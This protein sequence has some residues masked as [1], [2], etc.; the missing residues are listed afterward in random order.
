MP[1][2]LRQS[3]GMPVKMATLQT[4]VLPPQPT[5]I[6]YN[7]NSRVLQLL[8]GETLAAGRSGNSS[9]WSILGRFFCGRFMEWG[10]W[11]RS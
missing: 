1:K 7:G 3:T 6:E 4:D 5:Q 9:K 11:V 8:S 10:T 2:T